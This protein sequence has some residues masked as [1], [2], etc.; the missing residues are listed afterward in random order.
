[1]S[2]TFEGDFRSNQPI[3]LFKKVGVYFLKKATLKSK[4]TLLRIN[5][6]FYT[7][8]VFTIFM[9]YI[10]QLTRTY[11]FNYYGIP[12]KMILIANKIKIAFTKQLIIPAK[13]ISWY[14]G[15]QISN[16]ILC[17]FF[18]QS[19]I[20]SELKRCVAEFNKFLNPSL[21][22]KILPV[23][24]E[25][26]IIF[27]NKFGWKIK[28]KSGLVRYTGNSKDPTLEI[29]KGWGS[30]L[31]HQLEAIKVIFTEYN[32]SHIEVTEQFFVELIWEDSTSILLLNQSRDVV[33]DKKSKFRRQNLVKYSDYWKFM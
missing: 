26:V 12:G 33:E 15:I 5:L 11:N 18:T 3:K 28:S 27:K 7:K 19:M 14:K 8:K 16:G 21:F 13:P 17:Y 29:Y 9:N 1:M 32:V 24:R 4:A 25:D 22:T 20:M 2:F 6:L 30:L 23:K 10:N 31:P